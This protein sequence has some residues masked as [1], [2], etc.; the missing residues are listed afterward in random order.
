MKKKRDVPKFRRA[1]PAACE[2]AMK[3]THP[4]PS[5]ADARLG[6]LDDVIGRAMLLDPA[7]R[8]QHGDVAAIGVDVQVLGIEMADPQAGHAASQY[9]R[10]TPRRVSTARSSSIAV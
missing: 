3:G 7:A 8:P 10:T 4:K 5:E 9:G 2:E 6:P 1:T